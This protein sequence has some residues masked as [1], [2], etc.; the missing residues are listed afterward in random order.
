MGVGVAG[1]AQLNAAVLV[2]AGGCS[3]TDTVIHKC[4]L[5]LYTFSGENAERLTK[6]LRNWRAPTTRRAMAGKGANHRGLNQASATIHILSV[7]GDSNHWQA[8]LSSDLGSLL[9]FLLEVKNPR[10]ALGL[11]HRVGGILQVF[12]QEPNRVGIYGRVHLPAEASAGHGA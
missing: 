12:I 3:G 6:N 8:A 4:A 1:T 10:V 5:L 9:S 11:G 7:A 2:A